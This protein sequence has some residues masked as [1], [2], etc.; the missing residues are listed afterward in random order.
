MVMLPPFTLSAPPASL[1]GRRIYAPRLPASLALE[2]KVQIDAFWDAVGVR[3]A[4]S[5][6]VATEPR[7]MNA[8][9]RRF[10][11]GLGTVW[12]GDARD[13]I[14]GGAMV[15]RWMRRDEDMSQDAAF[16]AGRCDRVRV[17]PFLEGIPCSIHG[18]V[19]EDA[20]ATF[21]PVEMVTLRPPGSRLRYCGAATFWD[22]PA[23]DREYMRRTA[24]RVGLALRERIRFR[25]PFTID[26]VMS[27]DGFL[28][29]ELNPRAGAGLAVLGRSVPELPLG[30]LNLAVTE[31]EP[32]E[33][34]PQDL[35]SLVVEAADARRRG[36][37]WTAIEASH[38]LSEEYRLVDVGTAYR[39][40]RD[41]EAG[42]AILRIGPSA[43]GGFVQFTP[44]PA[45]VPAGESVGP[46]AVAA[47]AL[48]DREFGTAIG[49]LLSA[50]P[51]R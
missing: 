50:R 4:P 29:T 5:E 26:G 9:A 3:R 17:M 40:A 16:F 27:A 28:P 42:D 6:V 45:R 48:A 14:H 44:D 43:V 18:I 39:L 21:R 49:P 36:G 15:C 10:D 20:V 31:G 47:F 30:L 7:A 41:R 33:F 12:A 37:G 34:R 1:E 2:D 19:F 38:D 22:P 51:V 32:L 13:G 24:R 46:R 35:E 23:G 25:G 11:R 8:A